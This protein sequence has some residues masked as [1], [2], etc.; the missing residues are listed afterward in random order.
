MAA[1]ATQTKVLRIGIIQ[2]GKIVQ[3]RLIKHG[4]NVL[5]GE[6]PKNTFVFPKTRLPRAEF[7]L[8]T[9]KSGTYEL[10][11][12]SEMKGKISSGGAV[13][14][15]DK[16]RSDPSVSKQGDV[17][18]L[19]LNELDR[20]K[21][22]IDN[23][24]ILFQFV[25]PPPVAA[26]KPIER[27]DFRPAMFDEDDPAFYGFL[28][29][30]TALATVFAVG[31]YLAPPPADMTFEEISDRF[32][33]HMIEVKKEEEKKERE[34]EDKREEELNAE[35]K[36]KKEEPVEKPEEKVVKQVSKPKT[37]IDQARAA[38]QR[39]A[40]LRQKMKIA[41]IGTRGRSSSGTTT[42]AWEGGV[43]K[44]LGGLKAGDVDVAGSAQGTRGGNTTTEDIDVSGD[45]NVGEAGG[46]SAS[47]VPAVDM[48][49][50]TASAGTG[51]T[52]DVEGAE[53]L[54]AVVRKFQG[55][56]SYCYEEQL[57]S[58]PS[59]SGRVE[60]QWNV[61]NKRV[62]SASVVSNTTGNDQLASCIV[63]KIRRW[64]FGDDVAGS[65][66]WPFVFRKR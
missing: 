57:R 7:P 30:F 66:T 24:T 9:A 47:A 15:L 58:D 12:S 1:Q 18:R 62:T 4:E 13:V 59:L 40:A 23:V 16:L 8:F 46:S 55:Q 32:A 5:V 43:L 10:H 49:K 60:V 33:S 26:V 64:R 44:D 35:R 61:A 42:D 63:K 11:F 36:E 27:M 17:W 53:N 20:G 41:Q 39:K 37:K 38:E 34:I 48:T 50:Y 19:P 65:T 51:D 6:S 45:V 29:L 56:L 52:L 2:D 22:G 25:P 31:I 14:S 3:E 28:A 54:Q 21:I